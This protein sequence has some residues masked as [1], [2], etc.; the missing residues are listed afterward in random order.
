MQGIH[1]HHCISQFSPFCSVPLFLFL[2]VCM[3]T[4]VFAFDS[5]LCMFRA[6]LCHLPFHHPTCQS[7]LS[8]SVYLS[9]SV[10]IYFIPRKGNLQNTLYYVWLFFFSLTNKPWS[11]FSNSTYIPE[12]FFSVVAYDKWMYQTFNHCFSD[13]N[14]DCCYFFLGQETVQ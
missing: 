14:L 12:P 7:Y 1:R 6:Y 9:T 8:S 10:C 4:E 13:M 3:T 11:S 5:K 2:H